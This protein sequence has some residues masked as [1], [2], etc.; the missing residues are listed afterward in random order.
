[1]QMAYP[2]I[3]VNPSIFNGACRKIQAAG[4]MFPYVGFLHQ[5][6]FSLAESSVRISLESIMPPRCCAH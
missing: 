5:D 4:L 2:S 6:K 3:V 1:M